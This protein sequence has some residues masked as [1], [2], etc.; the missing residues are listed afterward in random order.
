MDWL[1][2]VSPKLARYATGRSV[3]VDNKDE[4]FAPALAALGSLGIDLLT[5]QVGARQ[6]V[7]AHTSCIPKSSADLTA[8]LPNPSPLLL[9]S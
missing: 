5:E 8:T 9:R 4:R 6:Y 3:D 7:Y 2:S 1:G